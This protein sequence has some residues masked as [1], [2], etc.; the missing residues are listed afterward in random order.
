MVGIVL[1]STDFHCI[2]PHLLAL[3]SN[4]ECGQELLW[5]K[6]PELTDMAKLGRKKGPP[7]VQ[8][9]LTLHPAVGGILQR[10]GN[11]L[12]EGPSRVVSDLIIK[13][14]EDIRSK[15]SDE[16]LSHYDQG[17]LGYEGY[18]RALERVKRSRSRVVA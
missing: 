2:P 16:E 6:T 5:F 12:G 7:R 15:L 1:N 9:V 17:T 10:A 13:L 8:F 3:I 11:M 18:L 14:D 4:R